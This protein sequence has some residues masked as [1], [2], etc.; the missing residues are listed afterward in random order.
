[1]AA[2]DP[3]R[4]ASIIHT[5]TCVV[6]AVAYMSPEQLRGVGVDARSDIWSLG[7]VLQEMVTGRRPF[8]APAHA[9]LASSILRDDPAPL[10]PQTPTRLRSIVARALSKEKSERYG[11]V[12]EMLAELRALLRD[13]D[14]ERV[15]RPSTHGEQHVGVGCR[16][17]SQVGASR[18]LVLAAVLAVAA[19]FAYHT[20]RA[21]RAS[22]LWR[23]PFTNVGGSPDTEYLSDGITDSLI[24]SLSQLPNVKVMSRNSVFR[25]K[26]PDTDALAAARQLNVRAVLTGRVRQH[27]DAFSMSVELV[28]ARDNSILWDTVYNRNLADIITVQEEIA[29]EISEKLR[30]RLTGEEQ[31]LLTKRYTEDT[32]AYQLYLKG[33]YFW[34]KFTPE[35]ERTAIDY[36]TQ[37]IVKDPNFALPYAG[38]VHGYQVSANNAWMRPHDAY[39]KAKAALAKGLELDPHNPSLLT[40]AASTAMFYDWDWAT[41]ER[42]FKQANEV[43]PNY[44]HQHKNPL[45]LTTPDLEQPSTSDTGAEIDPLSLI[46][47]ASASH[48]FTFAPVRT[49]K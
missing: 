41:A 46:A 22:T 40:A 35:A 44:W 45:S 19:Y 36:Y 2:P 28:D 29:K 16:P 32:E 24:S 23:L 20:G 21:P 48:H 4:N 17:T 3:S 5:E 38:L 27:G 1:M 15:P 30:L 31:K 47:H 26:G 11:N 12:S 25:F 13:T 42:G 14:D 18:G 6:M 33:N 39:P 37:A 34:N 8:Q 9:D 7:V 43:E 10:P 49:L